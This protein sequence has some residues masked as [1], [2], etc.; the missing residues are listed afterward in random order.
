MSLFTNLFRK[1]PEPEAQIKVQLVSSST[2]S[3]EQWRKD[4]RLVASAKELERHETFRMMVAVLENSHPRYR[5]FVISPNVPVTTDDRAA[6]QAKIEGYQ[7]CLNNL[8]AMSQPMSIF[9]TPEAKFEPVKP[10]TK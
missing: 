5:A 10:S 6:H 8:A 2:L 7:L 9:Q 1:S 4:S 3:L